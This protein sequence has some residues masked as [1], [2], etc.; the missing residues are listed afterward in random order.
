MSNFIVQVF[1]HEISTRVVCINGKN[2]ES[3]SSRAAMGRTT[4]HSKDF[5]PSKGTQRR[6]PPKYIEITLIPIYRSFRSLEMHSKRRYKICIGSVILGELE[7]FRNYSFIFAE[8][9]DAEPYFE[10]ENSSDSS[11]HPIPSFHF[12][13]HF[14]YKKQ[15]NLFF[16]MEDLMELSI[17]FVVQTFESSLWMKSQ[18]V[19]IQSEPLKQYFCI[20]LIKK[21]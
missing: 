14:F 10:S 4:R 2:P 20:I 6:F 1:E 18:D 11:F 15:P 13:F 3:I 7:P 5:P 19:S 12:S 17:W 16:H 9:L 21:G 8:I